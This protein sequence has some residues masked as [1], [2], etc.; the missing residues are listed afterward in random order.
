MF[1]LRGDGL[2]IRAIVDHLADD[3]V[4]TSKTTVHR[5]LRDNPRGR[6]QPISETIRIADLPRSQIRKPRRSSLDCIGAYIAALYAAD[7]TISQIRT[8]LA[9]EH[10]IARSRSTITAW[11]RR[12]QT[13][14]FAAPAGFDA[15]AVADS[16]RTPER[17]QSWRPAAID[18]ANLR[19]WVRHLRAT[20]HTHFD[21]A[22]LASKEARIHISEA[23]V[24]NWLRANPPK[25]RVRAYTTS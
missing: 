13:T 18:N 3:G 23:A 1:D 14:V 22:V 17:P 6:R 21:I 8:W 15:V 12:N 5:I 4:A 19:D 16:L 24:R 9:D 11:I 7:A 20:R 25:P 10:G 2:S